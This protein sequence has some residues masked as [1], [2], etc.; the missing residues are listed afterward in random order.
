MA[1]LGVPSDYI[2]YIMGHKLS[3]CH[4]VRMKGIEFLPSIY[5][6]ANL[7]IFQKQKITLADILKE[8]I[9]SRGEDPSKYLKEQIMAGRVVLLRRRRRRSM[10]EQYGR[11]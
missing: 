4:D 2:E 6:A 1:A 8:I 9:R 3:T 10:L 7:K 11:C 5:A